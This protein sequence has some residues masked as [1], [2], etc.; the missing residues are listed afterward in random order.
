VDLTKLPLDA[1]HRELGARMVPFA[2]HEMPVQYSGVMAEHLHTRASA[3]LFDVSHMGQ[4]T[5][6][7]AGA[8]QA[9]ERVVPQAVIDLPEGRQRYGYLTT[10]AGGVADDLILANRGDHL[11]LVVNGAVKAADVA[12]LRAGLP[13]HEVRVEAR[14]LLALQGPQAEAVLG[15]LLPGTAAMRFMDVADHDWRG[16]ALWVARSGYTGEDGFEI[17][18][19]LAAA[20]P[21]ARAL[22]A[23][24][25]VL[26]VG[27]GA[28]DSLRLEAG[29]PL[30]GQDLGEAISPVEAGLGWA[31]QKVRRSGGAREGG[32]P[33]AARILAELSHGAPRRR[34]GLRPEGR[35]PMRAG[36][37]LYE[38]GGVEPVGAVTS[39]GFGPSVGAPVAMGLIRSNIAPDAVLEGEVRG[40]RLP[41]SVAGLPF[42]PPRQKR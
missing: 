22:L 33:G 15:A 36:V 37:M 40:R 3:G 9:L 17:S 19:P 34:A 20:E 24:P 23:D 41:V 35:A 8:A 25:R 38:P 13:D 4:V 26:P 14:A 39:G 32:F 11:L 5:I 30:Y 42:V 16:A 12:R 10:E 27:L 31:I 1:L 2:G 6:H 18:V 28:R 29:L 21:F 7:G